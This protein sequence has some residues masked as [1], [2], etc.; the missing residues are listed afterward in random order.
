[1]TSTDRQA[2]AIRSREAKARRRLAS[3]AANL[4]RPWVI[5]QKALGIMSA[6]A[7]AWLDRLVDEL[8]DGAL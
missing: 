7:Q 6:N 3:D 1:M 5:R 2:A 4:V 8:E